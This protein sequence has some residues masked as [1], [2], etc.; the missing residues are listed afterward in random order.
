MDYIAIRNNE[1][2][3]LDKIPVHEYDTFRSLILSWIRDHDSFHCVNY[4][5]IPEESG[6]R[7]VCLLADDATGTIRV[8]SYRLK[9]PYVPVT[10]MSNEYPGFNVFERELHENQGVFFT[11][12]PWLKPLRYPFNRVDQGQ[13][14]D[15][16]P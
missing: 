1:T 11:D 12:H 8:L 6:I 13:V 14:I 16:Y 10:S 15:N 5:G 9:H 4:F 2:V 3:D 7:P